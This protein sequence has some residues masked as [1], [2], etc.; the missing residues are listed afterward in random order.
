[1]ACLSSDELAQIDISNATME[2][3]LSQLENCLETLDAD[4]RLYTTPIAMD[5]LNQVREYL[6]YEK[7]NLMGISYG[8]RAA[9][10]YM[11]RHGETVRTAVHPQRW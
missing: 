10:V 3:E 6:G 4:T 11:R 2:T 1:M 8:T 9:L 5:D 7:I